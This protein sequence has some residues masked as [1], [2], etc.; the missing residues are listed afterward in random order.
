MSDRERG[1][2]RPADE[3]VPLPPQRAP[4]LPVL[5]VGM[6]LGS[7]LAI[8][9]M[10]CVL[11]DLWFPELA[12][13]PLWSKLL[14]GFVWLTWPSFFL[15]LILSFAYG[16]YVALVLGPLFNLFSAWHFRLSRAVPISKTR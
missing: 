2:S 1:S 3:G 11:F 14:P 5:A 9:Y 13:N 15:G 16:W 6:S 10:L 12:M 7:F 8:T 4:R